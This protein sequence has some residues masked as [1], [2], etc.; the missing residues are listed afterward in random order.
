VVVYREPMQRVAVIPPAS[1][2][3]PLR[4]LTLEEQR[5]V[6]DFAER[7]PLLTPERSREIAAL[8]RPLSG[9]SAGGETE[10][11]LGV[12]NYLSGPKG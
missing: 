7:S 11:L 6:L 3:A 4:S 10:R 2:V 8:A 5:L 9:G 12:A 1:A